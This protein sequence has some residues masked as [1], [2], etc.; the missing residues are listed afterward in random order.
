M[1]EPDKDKNGEYGQ[2]FMRVGR[3]GVIVL[4]PIKQPKEKK[5]K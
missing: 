4:P 3:G 1:S 5:E 2:R